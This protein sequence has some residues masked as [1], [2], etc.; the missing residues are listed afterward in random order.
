MTG[1]YPATDAFALLERVWPVLL[2]VVAITVV[3]ELA[4]EAGLFDL[5]AAWATRVARG[6]AWALWLLTAAVATV[7]TIF[8]SLDTTA[9][10]LTP[11]VVTMARHVRLNPLPFALTTVMLANTASL[12]LPVSNL[13]NLLA[14]QRL[15]GSSAGGSGTAAFVALSWA[16]A[17]VAVVLPCIAIAVLGRK[18]LA[19]RFVVQQRE[20][21]RDPRLTTAAAV[22]VLALLPALVSGMPVWI[23]ACVAAG[24]LAIVFA[25]LRRDVLRVSLVPWSM[26]VFAGGMFL[27]AGAV[28]AIGSG[29]VVREL[30]GYGTSPLA[31]LRVSGVGLLGANAANNLPAY[32]ALEPAA[33]HPVQLMALLIGVNVGPLITPWASLATLLWHSRLQRL[34]V[35]VPWGRYMVIGVV[36]APVTVIAAT[37]ALAAIT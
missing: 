10:L 14:E 19:A 6:S 12:L 27:A 18:N 9:V 31:L 32:L 22:V 28:E 24:V 5:L 29:A 1:L 11:I 36:V 30:V 2:F 26:V 25:V 20:K 8:L 21:L 37:L 17:L 16:P 15:K 3:A 13:T 23:P 7:S 35:G 34:G 33:Q 4:A